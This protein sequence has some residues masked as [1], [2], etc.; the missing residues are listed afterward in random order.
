MMTGE[1]KP[2]PHAKKHKASQQLLSNE[3]T[4]TASRKLW[5]PIRPQILK[6]RVK[7]LL[8]LSMG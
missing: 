4:L 8:A 5:I 3:S 7:T 2:S 6:G 1:N